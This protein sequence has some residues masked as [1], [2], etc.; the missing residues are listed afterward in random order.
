MSTRD[1][2]CN[3]QTN[4]VGYKSSCAKWTQMSSYRR[5]PEVWNLER[6]Q[7]W[8]LGRRS[9]QAKQPCYWLHL[10]NPIW[11]YLWNWI[12]LITYLDRSSFHKIS[13]KFSKI[14]ESKLCLGSTSYRTACGFTQLILSEGVRSNYCSNRGFNELSLCV[15]L[16]FRIWLHYLLILAC[17]DF[18]T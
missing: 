18:F 17:A 1:R 2:R 3:L 12:I 11:A 15:N 16:W 9:T 14:W 7:R 5:F 6:M 8:R 10:T 4:G 13:W